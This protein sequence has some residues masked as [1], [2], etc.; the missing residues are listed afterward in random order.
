MSL[1]ADQIASYNDN[2]YLL[3][4]GLLAKDEAAKLRDECQ[5]LT[6]RL[7]RAH[8]TDATWAGARAM[9]AEKTVIFHCHNVQFYSGPL[10]ALMLDPRFTEIAADL[11]GPN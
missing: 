3:V 7:N 8:D 5:G 9:V 6:E 4:K 11:I 2:G 10:A 1:T